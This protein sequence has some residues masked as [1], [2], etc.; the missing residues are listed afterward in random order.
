M[1]KAQKNINILFLLLFSAYAIYSI[2]YQNASIFFIVYLFWFDELIRS[3][4][5]YIQ[6]KMHKEDLRTVREFTKEQAL[7]NVKSRFF[8]LFVYSVFIVIIFGLFFHLAKNN[9]DQLVRNIRIFL[10]R[11]IAFNICIMIAIVR[12]VIQIRTTS[13][14][15]YAPIPSFS[16]MSGNLLT[17]HISIILGAFMWA[18]TSGKFT[19]FS[20]TLGSFNQ[21]AIVLP[22]FIVKFCVD[23]YNINHVDKSKK[24]LLAN[25]QKQ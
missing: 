8:F 7:S 11:D 12:E 24:S 16:A 9:S 19:N 13:L 18:I 4:S 6:V 20:F 23:I 22:F 15:R 21:Y 1:E 3:I 5:M 25:L 2:V 17:L 14:N 10:F